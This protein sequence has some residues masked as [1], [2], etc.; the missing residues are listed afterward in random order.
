MVEG[1]ENWELI[2]LL[3]YPKSEEINRNGIFKKYEIT[4]SLI[5]ILRGTNQI[6]ILDSLIETKIMKNIVNLLEEKGTE[7][8]AS[9]RHSITEILINSGYS[10]E[11]YLILVCCLSM[12]Y[13]KE[14]SLGPKFF[15][16]G[17]YGKEGIVDK[18]GS[19]R[20]ML[21]CSNPHLQSIFIYIYIYIPILQ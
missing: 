21:L 11:E 17:I 7:D 18:E 8:V 19:Q 9:L 15:R 16:D 13:I 12:I 1:D 5:E 3:L 20:Q 6:G 4:K 2:K 10:A 14:N